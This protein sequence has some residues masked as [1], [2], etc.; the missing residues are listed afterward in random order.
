MCHTG[1]ARGINAPTVFLMEG[2]N[3]RSGFSDEYLVESGC[4]VGS[5]IKM[6]KMYV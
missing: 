5:T 2:E 4:A 6:Q 3:R 1:T